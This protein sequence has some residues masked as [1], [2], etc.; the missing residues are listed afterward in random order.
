M[1]GKPNTFNSLWEQLSIIH[2]NIYL[3]SSKQTALYFYAK[4]Q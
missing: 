3:P 1:I 4:T 2:K